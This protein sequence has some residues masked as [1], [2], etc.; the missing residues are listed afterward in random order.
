M[1]VALTARCRHSGFRSAHA[2]FLYG[3]ALGRPG[4]K[5]AAVHHRNQSHCPTS[6]HSHPS[7]KSGAYSASQVRFFRR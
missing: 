3:V 7:T 6:K 5:Q 2:S 4:A 1:H